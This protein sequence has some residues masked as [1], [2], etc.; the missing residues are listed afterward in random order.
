MSS[1]QAYAASRRIRPENRNTDNTTPLLGAG[2]QFDEELG[3]ISFSLRQ[4]LD[5]G[6]K[7]K[8]RRDMRCR[9]QRIAKYWLEECPTYAQEGVRE[10]TPEELNDPNLYFFNHYK[11]DI[12]YSGLRPD[13]VLKFLLHIK[14]KKRTGTEREKITSYPNMRKYRDA[15]KW[16]AEIRN[17]RLHEK[18]WREMEAFLGSYK[19]ETVQAKKT[20]N[21]D[22]TEADGI[23]IEL[24]GSILKWCVEEG[25]SFALFWTQTQWNCM[26]R[27]ISVDPLG[28]RNFKLG[29]DS[30]ICKY[31]D[32]KADNDGVRCFEKNIYAN[33]EN[34]L[35]CQWT[36]MGLYCALNSDMLATTDKLFFLS[37]T[38]AGTAAK[39]YQEQLHGIVNRSQ[40]RKDEVMQH[41]RLNH[42][43]AYGFRKGAASHATAG[44]TLPPSL[45]SV[46]HR[47]EWSMGS[48]FDVYWKFLPIGDH[49]LG[50]IL[51]GKDPNKA[52]FASLPPHWNCPDP[53]NHPDIKRAIYMAFGPILAV[54]GGTDC[55][56]T[57]I[58]T[59]CLA[60]MIWHMDS[61]L[62]I[63]VSI[64]G[65][66]YNKLPLLQD[67]GL[68]NRLKQLVTIKPTIGVMTR[69]TGV[70]PHVELAVQ[71]RE[72]FEKMNRLLQEYEDNDENRTEQ[73]I[74]AIK[75]TIENEA[76]SSG[77]VSGSRML[78]ILQDHRD[79]MREE[80]RG[81]MKLAREE[82]MKMAN[83]SGFQPAEDSD[84]R[85]AVLRRSNGEESN[86]FS[87]QG[88]MF[89]W[90]VPEDFQFP[91]RPKLTQ[92][93]RLWL[94][95]QTVSADGLTFV[96]PYRQLKPIRLPNNALQQK[97]RGQWQQLFRFVEPALK[98]PR[99]TTTMSEADLNDAIKKMWTHLQER[100]SYCF[101]NRGAGDPKQNLLS[102]WAK[103]ISKSEIMKKGTEQDKASHWQ[104]KCLSNK[105]EKF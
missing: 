90:H 60:C 78:R 97:L 83:A 46:A 16:G 92:A 44:T 68:L 61:I 72:I 9:L 76:L 38:Q 66:E 39:K 20:G 63:M 19:R 96:R 89:F 4:T 17:E 8:T 49:Y 80:V 35:M 56:P 53:L 105:K 48:V 100:V 74:E 86:S 95:G 12:V 65:H 24:Y 102:Y 82:L 15:I 26:A 29:L 1:H 103:R 101:V 62:N 70:P 14:N 43:N 67:H 6:M 98:L 57:G 33:S 36:G 55:D 88:K 23:S 87:Y 41:C 2:P 59:R 77:Q 32:S 5:F 11:Y 64:P 34:W 47:G 54:H 13:F 84:T 28:F 21:L 85:L 91:T 69:V 50:Q 10:N 7:E 31:D 3:D 79:S 25:N 22:E 42:F 27:C 71:L 45:P 73:I 52:S 58:L 75:A 37:G 18:F 51:S 99:D 40:Q 93:L 81:E 104:W 30:H 94:K